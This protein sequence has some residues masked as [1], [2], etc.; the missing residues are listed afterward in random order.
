[1]ASADELI[2]MMVTQIKGA[3]RAPFSSQPGVTA[4]VLSGHVI[5]LAEGPRVEVRL[6]RV[7][8]IAGGVSSDL[9]GTG[10]GAWTVLEP[11]RLPHQAAQTIVKLL[12]AGA[13]PVEPRK[14]TRR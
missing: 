14:R 4:V 1:M 5:A 3:E 6:S 13:K 7:R 10:R 2:G 12:S 11:E 9:C 8:L